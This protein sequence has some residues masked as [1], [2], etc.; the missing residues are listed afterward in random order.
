[1]SEA[2]N[3]SQMELL[4]RRAATLSLAYNAFQT[5]V[6]LGAAVLTGSVSL[7]SEAI[8]SGTDVIASF[9][10][11]LSVRAASAPPDDEHPYGHGKI[12]SLA[13]FSESILLMFIVVYIAIEAV[14]RLIAGSAAHNLQVGMWIMLGASLSNLVVGV[15]VRRIGR[16][17][18]SIA[19]LSNGNHL[20]VDFWTSA[21]VLLALAITYFTPWKHADPVV[22]IILA[23]WIGWNSW[24]MSVEAFHQLIDRQISESELAEI[25]H[26]LRS[27]P[28][29]LSYHKLRTRHSGNVHYI[30]LHVVVPNDWSVVQAHELA[31]SL[32]KQIAAKL[33]PA[34]V[35]IHVDPFDEQKAR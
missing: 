13:G 22:A 29:V 26:I 19:L 20:L 7:L 5:L 32:E 4:K 27:E 25:H 6:K 12:E 28:K 31:D 21:G 23:T 34:Q 17:S 10:A 16:H 15:Y 35:V 33:D 3:R 2:V 11:Y 24:H 9:I 18:A 30:D 1:M 8:H 14:Q